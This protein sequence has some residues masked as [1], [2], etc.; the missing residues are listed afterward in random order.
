[1]ATSQDHKAR[2]N[3]DKGPNTGGMGAYS[4][5]PI[6]SPLV[7]DDAMEKI[8]K[9]TVEAMK[10]EGMP[11]TGFLYAGLMVD[12]KGMTKVLEY[13][14]TEVVL[15]LVSPN[16]YS[17]PALS[18]TQQMQIPRVPGCAGS[19]GLYVR[20]RESY[21]NYSSRQPQKSRCHSSS[22]CVPITCDLHIAVRHPAA[23]LLVDVAIGAV[24]ASR[25]ERYV[26]P[27]SDTSL[28]E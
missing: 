27:D 28:P 23:T 3:G 20:T 21:T 14:C 24:D 7:F 17:E 9:P 6:V 4:P 19:A 8:I 5:A 12:D 2:D 18:A 13:N 11:Y 16:P 10:S 1:M 15:N 22:S 25:S 26:V